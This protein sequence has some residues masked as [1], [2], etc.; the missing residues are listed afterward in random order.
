MMSQAI[1]DHFEAQL[2]WWSLKKSDVPVL[3]PSI[4]K[5]LKLFSHRKGEKKEKE[6]GYYS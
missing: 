5:I 3:N 1:L 2:E 4:G 6:S